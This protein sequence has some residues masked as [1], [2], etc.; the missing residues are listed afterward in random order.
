MFSRNPYPDHH[1]KEEMASKINVDPTVLQVWFKNQRAK[2]KKLNCG[3]QHVPAAGPQLFPGDE[4][5]VKAKVSPRQT[6]VVETTP[7]SSPA[8]ATPHTPPRS[9]PPGSPP[10]KAP[11]TAPLVYTNGATP[12]YQLRVCPTLEGPCMGHK[13]IH[14]SCCGDAS[15]YCLHPIAES[16][17][18]IP[19]E[20]RSTGR[21]ILESRF[22][23]PDPN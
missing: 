14:F 7:P 10:P 22:L 4:A 2:L 16:P 13:M 23:C 21:N 15:I 20:E 8:Q 19:R 6:Q 5:R 12:S 17:N 18:A 1:D 3:F 9:P 11:H